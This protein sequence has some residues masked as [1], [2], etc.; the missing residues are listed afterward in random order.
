MPS[1]PDKFQALL[2]SWG[3]ALYRR[4]LRVTADEA[5]AARAAQQLFVRLLVHGRIEP[6]NERA[7]W[8][9]IYRA[10]TNRG[11]QLL[12]A[13]ARPGGET[14]AT[15]AREPLPTMAALR[16]FDEATQNIVVLTSLDGLSPQEV[17]DV[18]GLPVTTVGRK[19]DEWRKK[20]GTSGAPSGAEH[21]SAFA[22]D[23]ER[24]AHE[25]HLAGCP[26]CRASIE[27][28]ERTEL[29][30]A[31][32]L[33][34]E[35]VQRLFTQV[36]A[37]RKALGGGIRWKRI[38]IL[39]ASLAGV[40]VMAFAVARPKA[41]RPGDLPF[42]G[43][44]T[45]SRAKAAGLQITVRRGTDIGAFVPGASSRLGDRLHFRVRA[46]GPRYF[47]L[48]VRGPQSMTRLFPAEGDKAVLV[49]PGQALD[50]DYI[51]EGPLAAPGRTLYLEGFFSE[52]EFVLDRKPTPDIQLVPVR[53]DV[54]P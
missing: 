10:G 1:E 25:A 29:R 17:A 23:R 28:A 4:V 47:G 21:P 44:A 42:R 52:H 38:L 11:L 49:K 27:S 24:A 15:P 46:E 34:P 33:D 54:E 39:T 26:S 32:T 41:P 48:R 51:V 22:L 16:E 8:S 30:F 53:I 2:R 36:A 12:A 45:A 31:S 3:G 40:T 18:V 19:L 50:R 43:N 20:S 35:V 37:E 5:E 6:G 13:T 7:R 14:P 9:W